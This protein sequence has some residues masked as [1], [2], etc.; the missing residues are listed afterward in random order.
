[1]KKSNLKQLEVFDLILAEKLTPNQYYLLCC[2]HD[3]IKSDQINIDL[4]LRQLFT[5]DW[6]LKNNAGG[7]ELSL[8]AFTLIGKVEKLFK[9]RKEVADK[10]SMGPDYT[11]EIEVYRELF[12]NI[13][14]P[15]GVY[16][17]SAVKNLEP[18]F[19]WFHD[20]FDY[21]W[22]TIHKATKMYVNEYEIKKW[23][24]LKNS[25]YFI[26]KQ[27]ANREFMSELANYCEN[28]L[29]GADENKRNHF[30]SKVV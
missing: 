30:E 24:Y 4:E 28:I 8:K 21:S 26:R 6:L 5:G 10:A 7:V 17:R 27:N 11:K 23:M 22:D 3:K 16:A 18:A 15:S 14:L 29:N 25:Q 12:P 1:M 20:N 19:R 2:I 13:K 9:V